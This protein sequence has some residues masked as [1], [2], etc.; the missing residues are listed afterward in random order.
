[1]KQ[2]LKIYLELFLTFAKI[3]LFTFGGG[4]AMI[5]LIQKEA[6][7]HRH[8]ITEEE[9]LVWRAFPV[10]DPQHQLLTGAGTGVVHR[11]GGSDQQGTKRIV[12]EAGP[13]GVIAWP[14][15]LKAALIP[16][17]VGPAALKAALIPVIVGAASF[18]AAFSSVTAAAGPLPFV[19]GSAAAILSAV[20]ALIKV[21]AD[22][23]GV[24]SVRSFAEAGSRSVEGLPLFVSAAVAETVFSGS[25]AAVAVLAVHVSA[26]F[27]GTVVG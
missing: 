6:G 24:S 19:F 7:E 12:L 17:T 3:G 26:A 5:P 13:F 16:V 9:L 18:K 15:A 10:Q 20:V 4:Y 14:A 23:A 21:F 8:W 1:M 11:L 27:T 22:A 25:V 2:K